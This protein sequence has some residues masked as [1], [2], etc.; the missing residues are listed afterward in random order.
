MKP[1]LREGQSFGQPIKC[2][3]DIAGVLKLGDY[4][5]TTGNRASAGGKFLV[6]RI[7][8]FKGGKRNGQVKAVV[9]APGTL[10]GRIPIPESRSTVGEFN[11]NFSDCGDVWLMRGNVIMEIQK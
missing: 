8:Y 11:S 3:G 9:N 2:Q 5:E 10:W 4:L 6:H 7:E 1:I